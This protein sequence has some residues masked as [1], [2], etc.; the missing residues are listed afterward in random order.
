MSSTWLS[1]L[2]ISTYILQPPLPVGDPS[3]VVVGSEDWKRSLPT[4]K[5]KRAKMVWIDMKQ[6]VK[7]QKGDKAAVGRVE[8]DAL[9]TKQEDLN[10]NWWPGM[11]RWHLGMIC[12]GATLHIGEPEVLSI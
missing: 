8:T 3:E 6:T 12:E 11:R 10:E 5:T 4:L 2:G 1:Y 9:L 7:G